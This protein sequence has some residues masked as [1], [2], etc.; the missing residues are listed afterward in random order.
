MGERASHVSGG[1]FGP[2]PPLTRE[3]RHH[4]GGSPEQS[5]FRAVV[6]SWPWR[7]RPMTAEDALARLRTLGNS[8]DAEGALRFFKQPPAGYDGVPD[9]FLGVRAAPLRKLGKELRD[10]PIPETLQ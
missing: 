10:L 7:E 6:F 4:P 3:A 8:Q 2:L 1:V 5:P 9:V